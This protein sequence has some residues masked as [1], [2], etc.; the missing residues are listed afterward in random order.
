MRLLLTVLLLLAGCV[1]QDAG[2]SAVATAP[3]EAVAEYGD[4][5]VG[6]YVLLGD[7]RLERNFSALL[8]GGELPGWA[9]RALLGMSPGDVRRVTL[10]PGDAFGDV[11]TSLLRWEPRRFSVPRFVNLSPEEYRSAYGNPGEGAA[12]VEGTLRLRVIEA[13]EGYVLVEREPLYTRIN[14][15]G[16]VV[17]V[18]AN[19]THI[20][21]FFTPVLNLTLVDPDGGFITYR[22]A[23]AT[24]VLADRNHPLAGREV[25][26]ELR[27]QRLIKRAQIEGREVL[28]YTDLSAAVRQAVAL[29]RPLLLYVYSPECEACRSAEAIFRDV[30][31]R[32]LAERLV[33]V[34][35][36]ASTERALTARYGIQT[37]PA[38]LVLNST[39]HLLVK[40][41]GEVSAGDLAQVLAEL[42]IT[43]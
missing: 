19:A 3:D 18:T 33:F 35:V 31:L 22:D 7:F 32:L 10:P 37:A 8:G 6:S 13:G 27:L 39:G 30:R 9:E 28:W 25:T 23:N 43:P 17:E 16:G 34:R 14:T 11:N 36:D 15:T 26:A 1:S 12:A 24:H 5:V 20:T 29:D 2:P 42:G 40:Q 4:F 41:E 21:Y 38:V